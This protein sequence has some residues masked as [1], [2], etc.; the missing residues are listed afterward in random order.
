MIAIVGGG[1]VGLATAYALRDLHPVV[2]EKEREVAT[3]QTGHNSGVIHSGVYYKPGSQK[4]TL[5]VEGGRRMVEFCREHG[6]A[7][8]I[9][10][11][12]I[13]ASDPS[14]M[15]RLDE[16][17]RRGRANGVVLERVGPERLREIE[18]HA[19]GV[20]ALWL[21][22]VGIVDYGAVARKLASFVEVRRGVRVD[23]VRGLGARLVV[24]CAGLYSDRVARSR[25]RI[26]PFRG[27]YY[28]LRRP[29]LVQGLIYPV[30]DLTFP[31]LDV[32]FTKKVGGSVEV[33]PNAVLAL[34]REG[35]RWGDVNLR[36]LLD[37]VMYP[38]FWR[39]ARRHWRMGL[40]E[41]C[42]SLL[43][44]QFVRSAQL[45]VPEV[46]GED[47]LPGGSG[48]RAQALDPEGRL[49][50]DFRFEER[51]GE[52]HVLNAP[53]P[54]ATASLAIGRFIAERVRATLG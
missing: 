54:A 29:E 3:H 10:G 46:K 17:E 52:I 21:P 36:D 26:V 22:R 9:C 50:D 47:L 23:S 42:R 48:V 25:L 49:L 39:L 41:M 12:V 28:H 19:R 27:E 1:I 20:G 13:V 6:I 53:S 44:P 24:N 14:Q 33:G 11:K 32:H 16:L 45:Y 5:A 34:A 7:H 18:P 30:P 37:T 43:K 51:P 15:P 31:F 35:Y 2:F 8:E 38:G 4:A 40:K